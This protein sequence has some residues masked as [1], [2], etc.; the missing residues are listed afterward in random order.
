MCVWVGGCVC[1]HVQWC[2]L[3]LEDNLWEVN[4][5]LPAR[6]FQAKLSLWAMVATTFICGAILQD[7]LKLS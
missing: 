2:V 4:F 5:L 7:E 3:V 6:G 1:A